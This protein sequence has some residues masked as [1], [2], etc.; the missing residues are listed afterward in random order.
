MTFFSILWRAV[1]G[2][3]TAAVVAG[4]AGEL[5]TGIGVGQNL[6]SVV[7]MTVLTLFVLSGLR[8]KGRDAVS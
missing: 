2:F 8:G 6:A 5:L 3:V 4:F 1:A 7:F